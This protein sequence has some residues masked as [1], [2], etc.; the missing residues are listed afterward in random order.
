VQ[1]HELLVTQEPQTRHPQDR[2]QE[3]LQ[4]VQEIDRPQG[5]QE[6]SFLSL[7][8]DSAENHIL[9]DAGA[10]QRFSEE[11]NGSIV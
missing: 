7:L 8:A 11:Q 5:G 9:T 4:M 1:A 3:V 10:S 2:A 6:I